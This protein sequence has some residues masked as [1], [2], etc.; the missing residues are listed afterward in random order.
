VDPDVLIIDEVLGVGDQSFSAKC[1]A[2]I[3]EFRNA[4]KAMMVVSHSLATL[5]QLCDWGLWL[6]HGR[7]VGHG[8]IREVVQAYSS[9]VLEET[10]NAKS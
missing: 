2:R 7:V 4:G 5:G 1:F 9:H 10:V 3:M 6:D 8:P